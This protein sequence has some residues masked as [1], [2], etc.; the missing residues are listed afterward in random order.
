MSALLGWARWEFSRRIEVNGIIVY[1]I[2][3][4]LVK[5]VVLIGGGILLLVLAAR[6]DLATL[7]ANAQSELNL[8]AGAS[9]W[10]RLFEQALAKFGTHADPIAVGAILY[11]VLEVTE[12]VGLILRRRWAEYLVFVA[13]IA[14]LPLEI[15]E[16]VRKASALK[17]LALVLNI[18]IAVY[19][20]WR[21]QLFLSRKRSSPTE[22]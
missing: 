22:A 18:A 19:L 11:G 20:V 13:T 1:L 12:A 17:A 7:A 14:F 5:A 16:L 10:R 15:D 6:A 4:R 21:K 2:C 3:E 9:L 8:G